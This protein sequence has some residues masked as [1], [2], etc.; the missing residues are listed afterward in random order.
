MTTGFIL[1]QQKS[2]NLLH[3][4]APHASPFAALPTPPPFR[5]LHRP[6][7]RIACPDDVHRTARTA[8]GVTLRCCWICPGNS[9]FIPNNCPRFMASAH[10]LTN[11][12]LSTLIATLL[13]WKGKSPTYIYILDEDTQPVIRAVGVS[14]T[15]CKHKFRRNRRPRNTTRNTHDR[16]ITHSLRIPV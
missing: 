3:L 9:R 16:S 2:R 11:I 6:C 4:K 7:P 10:R 1:V 5:S 13:W 14:H 12:T 8:P 15:A